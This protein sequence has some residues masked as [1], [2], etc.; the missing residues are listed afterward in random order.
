MQQHSEFLKLSA[1][2]YREA[3]NETINAAR[4]LT[5]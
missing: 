1:K 5:N 3:Q 4:R 2:T